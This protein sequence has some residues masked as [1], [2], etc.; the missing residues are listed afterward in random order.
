MRALLKWLIGLCPPTSPSVPDKDHLMKL[1]VYRALQQRHDDLLL[2]RRFRIDNPEAEPDIL[3]IAPADVSGAIVQG[4]Y[5][6]LKDEPKV[7]C[8]Q[9]RREHWKANHRKGFLVRLPNGD[10]LL[11][12]ETCAREHFGADWESIRRQFAGVRTRKRYLERR[13]QLIVAWPLVDRE[14][15]DLE[16]RVWLRRYDIG[17]KSFA[18]R[19]PALHAALM[20]QLTTEGP[21][22]YRVERVRDHAAENTRPGS[23]PIYTMISTPIGRIAGDRFLTTAI[24]LQ[25]TVGKL[26]RTLAHKVGT[27]EVVETNTLSDQQLSNRVRS[28]ENI[29][30]KLLRTI[31]LLQALDA[32]MA[33]D[34]L[35]FVCAWASNQERAQGSYRLIDNAIQWD[36]HEDMWHRP[37]IGVPDLPQLVRLAGAG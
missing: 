22:I 27:L 30:A 29:A 35:K 21:T 24:P 6:R 36:G 17:A 23:G 28:V 7:R 1:D 18:T 32:F 16:K 13:E 5:K 14:L 3:A 33:L 26:H 4:Y 25:E 37:L 12:G 2:S 8:R 11:V 31:G 19:L 34:N 15:D 10:G 9:C 20:H